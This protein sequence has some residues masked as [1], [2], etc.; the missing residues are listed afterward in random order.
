MN[1]HTEHS[2]KEFTSSNEH[3]I[4]IA[5]KLKNNQGFFH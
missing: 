4:E 3:L 2:H 1:N 5:L